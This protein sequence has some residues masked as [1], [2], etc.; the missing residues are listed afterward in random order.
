M[1]EFWMNDIQNIMDS[2]HLSGL[3]PNMH[4]TFEEQLNTLTKLIGLITF[5][6]FL[7]NP[8]LKVIL[9]GFLCILAIII[10]YKNDRNTRYTEGFTNQAMMPY[11]YRQPY[12]VPMQQQQTQP[13]QPQQPLR[14]SM[15]MPMQQQHINHIPSAQQ[16]TFM[17]ASN[18]TSIYDLPTSSR[19][20]PLQEINARENN[21]ANKYMNRDHQQFTFPTKQNPMMNVLLPEIQSNPQRHPAANSFD[22]FI[23]KLIN[24]DG[25]DPKIFGDLGDNISYAQSMRNFYTNPSTTIPNSQKDFADFCY[26]NMASCKDADYLQC[27]KNNER[28]VKF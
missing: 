3:L 17:N 12:Q 13:Q 8:S 1:N 21:I 15:P 19:V 10:I 24:K 6:T 2:F 25:A 26:G 28:Y 9:T 18:T 7:I 5:I 16:N 27:Y 11:A 22:T 23:E 20:T 4:S 14:L